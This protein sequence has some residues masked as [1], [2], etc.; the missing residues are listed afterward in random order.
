MAENE[1]EDAG[2]ADAEYVWASA[3]G[4]ES[5]GRSGCRT[6]AIVLG[7][8]VV[9]FGLVMAFALP[10]FLVMGRKAK[11]GELEMNVN[12]IKTAQAAYM[13]EHGSFLP[14]GPHP[15]PVEALGP[16]QAE[17][18]SGSA[19]DELGWSPDGP[20][21]GTYQVVVLPDSSDFIVHG[22]IDAD[23]DGVPAHFTATW[24]SN[25]ERVTP[26]RVH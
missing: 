2:Q 19:F 7:L 1:G 15:R 23:S 14:A 10:R 18:T 12:G 20:V 16:G 24:R 8:L 13:A 26:K 4:S 25:A 17:W 11:V 22:W 5:G 9:C 3:N 21:R 6:F